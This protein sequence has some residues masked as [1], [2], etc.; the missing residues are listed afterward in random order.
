[1]ENLIFFCA[2]PD[3]IIGCAGLVLL[4]RERFNCHLVDF[5]SGEHLR[6]GVPYGELADRRKKEESA[7]CAIAG[8][9]PHF[10]GIP[11]TEA[12]ADRDKC[13]EFAR[14]FQELS[15]KAIFTHY[16]VD[17]HPDHVM[18]AAVAMKTRH[19]IDHNCELYFFEETFQTKSFL[20]AYTIDI[21]PVMKEKL[22]M[23]DCYTS[24]DPESLK[25]SQLMDD[26]FRCSRINV[27][28]AERYAVFAP[29]RN[30]VLDGFNSDSGEVFSL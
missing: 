20:P 12:F 21:T 18:T 13:E 24:Q 19:L 26:A 17:I 16:P 30:G 29:Y 28:Y 1:M 10:M 7:A 22:A 4:A 27:S 2:H 11:Q 8:I 15:P 6:E 3:D 9:T 25:R 23:I 5:T 14:I